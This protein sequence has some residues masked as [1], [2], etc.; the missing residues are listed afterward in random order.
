MSEVLITSGRLNSEQK[1]TVT[2][3]FLNA[4]STGMLF[5]DAHGVIVD[6][7][8][9]AARI[10]G[11][12]RDALLGAT[13]TGFD[14]LVIR[15]DGSPFDLDEPL[16][17]TV[18][19]S[20]REIPSTVAGIVGPDGRERWLSLRIWPE[21]V[22]GETVGVLAAFDDITRDVRAQRF[23]ALLNDFASL[24]R[25]ALAHDDIL[26]PICEL[27]TRT[28]RYAL[29]RIVVEGAD[30][31]HDVV[32]SAQTPTDGWAGLI[33]EVGDVTSGPARAVI[34][35]STPLSVT[36]LSAR[37]LD[38]AWRE[39]ASAFP[40]GSGACVPVSLG[41]RRGALTIYASHRDAF[42]DLSMEGLV[43]I[44]REI[45]ALYDAHQRRGD[46]DSHATV[47]ALKR[48]EVSLSESER[49][50]RTLV[51]KSS[52]I[53]IVIDDE[54]RFMYTNPVVNRLF[55]YEPSDLIGRNIL[56]F[57]HPDDQSMRAGRL[58][59]SNLRL[60]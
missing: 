8:E 11:T 54:G 3:D 6:C 47:D 42:D 30:G 18:L 24:A 34:D 44:A 28:G 1:L 43:T 26:N 31:K 4:I 22:D 19:R 51:A 41:G 9:A 16:Y 5:R 23:L 33:T 36:D 20:G 7:N 35:S 38:E 15:P 27:V 12:S 45:E 59:N 52:D 17:R 50:F 56:D 39:G 55:G 48:A 13:E 37:A 21:V 60:R 49:W 2:T 57:I 14:G 46:E 25:S 40:L 53:M 29:A 32:G 58:R 10:L